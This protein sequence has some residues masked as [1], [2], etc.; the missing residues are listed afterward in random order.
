[1]IWDIHIDRDKTTYPHVDTLY[2]AIHVVGYARYGSRTDSE[3]AYHY[4]RAVPMLWP[5]SLFLGLVGVFPPFYFSFLLG[6]FHPWNLNRTTAAALYYFTHQAGY[7]YWYES[8]IARET[9]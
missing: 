1:M 7:V 3:Y 2:L 4:C 9:R 8:T 5:V 6:G